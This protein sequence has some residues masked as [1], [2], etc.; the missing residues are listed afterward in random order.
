MRNHNTLRIFLSLTVA[1]VCVNFT[2]PCA[3][4]QQPVGPPP[5]GQGGQRPGGQGVPGGQ[6]PGGPGLPAGFVPGDY[7]GQY[8]GLTGAQQQKLTNLMKTMDALSKENFVPSAFAQL[9]LT[10]DEMRKI[11]AGGTLAEVLTADQQQTLNANKRPGRRSGLGGPGGQGGPGGFGGPGG[12]G[13]QGGPG[14]FGGQGGRD[15]NPPPPPPPGGKYDEVKPP[16]AATLQPLAPGV[17]RVPV[18]FS[19]GHDTDPRD[20][21]RPVVLVAN[22]LGVTPEIFR[23]AFSHVRPA[24]TGTEPEPAQV[25]QNK[26]ALLNALGKYGVDNDHLDAAS[27]YYRYVPGR[28]SLWTNRPAVAN[29]LV[30]N[31]EVIGYEIVQGGAGYT[32]PPTVTVPNLRTGR[33]A[34]QLA[35]GKNLATNGSVVSITVEPS[36]GSSL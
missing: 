26:A 29:A 10:E 2:M 16:A 20:R 13:N 18:V 23:E 11:A 5:G 8:L 27:N 34:A 33:A 4:A 6:R 12:A 25:Q 24:A 17:T 28:N 32:S 7:L 36:G 31:G 35:F 15:V 9:R 19:G 14:R 22:A 3:S 30:K 21:G 1:G